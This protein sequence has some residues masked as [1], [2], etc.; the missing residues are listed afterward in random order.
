MEAVPQCF[1]WNR[2]GVL[3]SLI[4]LHYSKVPTHYFDIAHLHKIIAY[5]I[6]YNLIPSK[7][8]ILHIT[9]LPMYHE[10]TFPDFIAVG[11]MWKER[12]QHRKY[13]KYEL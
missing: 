9:K 4:V 5:I 11:K 13:I 6:N 8:D 3:A 12:R 2:N 7:S 1:S 10:I